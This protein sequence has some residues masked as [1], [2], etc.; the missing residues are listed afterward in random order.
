MKLVNQQL[1]KNNNLKLIYDSIHQ[2]QGISRTQLAKLSRLSKTTVSSLVDELIERNFVYDSGASDSTAVGRKPNSLQLKS[3]QLYVAVICW[4]EHHIHAQVVD[5]CGSTVYEKRRTLGSGSYAEESGQLFFDDILKEFTREQILG[6]SIVVPAMIDMDRQE[7]FATTL[8]PQHLYCSNSVEQLKHIFSGFPVALL[9][10]TAC[11]AY[12]EKVYA[13]ISE[14]DFVFINF[15][16][17]IG[18]TLFIQNAMLGKATASYTQFGHYCVNPRGK[19]CSCGNR[20]C[21]EL[22][23]GESSLPERLQSA[24]AASSLSSLAEITYKDLG[25]AATYGDSVAQKIMQDI[26][27]DFSMALLNLVCLVH[28]KLVILGGRGKDLGPLFLEELQK[29][30]R[31]TGFRRMVDDVQVRY[32]MLDANACFKGAMKYFFDIHYDFTQDIS[33]EFFIG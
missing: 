11:T 6:I 25:L 26:V 30:L 1:I 32:G 18:A 17:G 22:T 7:I 14:Q 3:G 24:G 21:L 27:A 9:N 15:N 23:I 19:L 8:D 10:D 16:Q 31:T 33:G 20:G 2:E 4:S 12:A 28:P 29:T 13:R 5:I